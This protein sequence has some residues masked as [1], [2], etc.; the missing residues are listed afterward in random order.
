[1]VQTYTIE[2]EQAYP[3]MP[4]FRISDNLD[5]EIPIH[6]DVITVPIV[7]HNFFPTLSTGGENYLV[8]PLFPQEIQLPYTNR[9]MIPTPPRKP[10]LSLKKL[11]VKVE[12][13]NNSPP[14]GYNSTTA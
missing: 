7:S 12:Y 4:W 2:E 1:M 13:R 11:A 14:W 6:S 5:F 10:V 3:L 9:A 8:P